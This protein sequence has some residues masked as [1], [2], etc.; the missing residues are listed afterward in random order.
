MTKTR[1]IPSGRRPAVAHHLSAL[2]HRA[3]L[4]ALEHG[5][6]RH[7]T[8]APPLHIEPAATPLAPRQMAAA[9][10]AGGAT[11]ERLAASY[12]V[13]LSTYRDIAR[14][15]GGAAD[16]DDVGAV[17]AFFVAINLHA[18]HGVDIAADALKPLERQLRGVSRLAADWDAAPPAQRQV[19]FERIAI[20]SILMS[21]SLADAAAQGPAALADVRR[22][23]R[24]YLQHVLGLNPDR[25]T[26]GANGLVLCS[27][28]VDKA[29]AVHA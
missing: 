8:P 3:M 20:V 10:C 14:N 19:F 1:S 26:L 2:V 29:A 18:L 11:R 28:A 24:A 23:A 21:R 15:Q 17:M 12:E 13:C 22:S 4:G 7:G 16:V 25:V 9:Q 5:S 6:D 27:K